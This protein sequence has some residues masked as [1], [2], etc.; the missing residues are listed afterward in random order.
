MHELKRQR[1]KL[2]KKKETKKRNKE[3]KKK[4]IKTRPDTR[5]DCRGRLGRGRNAKTACNSKIFGTDKPTHQHGKELSCVPATQKY[6]KKENE[7][8]TKR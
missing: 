8:M 7:K 4:Y 6:R 2:R 3:R 1:E 5:Q